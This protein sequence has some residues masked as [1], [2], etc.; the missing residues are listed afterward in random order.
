MHVARTSSPEFSRTSP[1]RTLADAE[2]AG[3][4][5]KRPAAVDPT[6]VID[7]STP[8][9]CAAA[10]VPASRRAEV[11]HRRC[12]SHA[13]RSRRPSWSTP[14][15]ASRVVQGPGDP[16]RRPVPRARG[17]ADR[18]PRRRVPTRSSSPSRPRSPREIERLRA[19][20]AEI[21]A[22]GWTDGV[23]VDVV[24]GPEEYLFGEETAL[25]EVIDGRPRSP[26]RAAVP[27]RRR[28]GRR[29][30]RRS[31]PAPPTWR[32]PARRAS[33]APPTLAGNVETFANVP[34]IVRQR[35]RLVPRARHRRIAGHRRLHGERRHRARGVAEVELG[36]PLRD[37]I[38][39]I[40]GGPRPGVARC[41][42]VLS[43]VANPVHPRRRVRHAPQ[44]RGDAGRRHAAR[45]RRVH[46][47]RRLHRPRGRRRGRRPVPRRRVVRPV[48]PRA[49][50]TASRS[51]RSL[52]QLARVAATG[53]DLANSPIR[54]DLVA[55]RRALLP[56]DPATGGRGQHPGAIP[57]AGRT[58]TSPETTPRSSRAHR[59]AAGSRR[60]SR[61]ARRRAT[62]PSNPTGPTTRSTPAS[63]RPTVSTTT[64]A[65]EHTMP[66]PDPAKPEDVG[67]AEEIPELMQIE[68]ARTL[69]NDAR[70]G[71][72][73]TVSTTP[74][75]TPGPRPSS[76]RSA[77]AR[78]TSSSPGSPSRSAG[79]SPAPGPDPTVALG[80]AGSGPG[81]SGAAHPGIAPEGGGPPMTE[82]IVG[83]AGRDSGCSS[84]S[85][86]CILLLR[87]E[88]N[89][90]A[91][92]QEAAGTTLPSALRG[93][94]STYLHAAGPLVRGEVLGRER[95]QRVG[96]VPVGRGHDDRDHQLAPLVGRLPHHR[97]ARPTAG[98]SSSTSSTSRGYTLY[99]PE[100]ISS[101]ARPTMRR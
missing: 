83:R 17:R 35:R 29:R 54:L 81:G 72:T 52:E 39:Q 61:H 101:L 95:E 23:A 89:M 62:A 28:R 21:A 19:A 44:L 11:A 74:R 4:G 16:A 65:E 80:T 63:G 97:D 73:P 76:P 33:D 6:A 99:P 68:G 91:G 82:G 22:A 37:V 88:R 48:P 26:Y 75:S 34:G 12:Q 79:P 8:P 93:S 53:D 15:R 38:D 43:G 96:V 27:P 13:R 92:L 66:E 30:R 25:L 3:E 78:S 50:R 1:V 40:G 47:V 2:H 70:D 57:R 51:P 14:P 55:D 36:T 69:G 100:M 64:A 45:R 67:V 41:V 56:R 7:R 46:R 94:S 49:S 60:R 24:T 18:G 85:I 20:I 31:A 59:R 77:R 86:A 42:A 71:C 90:R 84:A 9:A 58:R 10:A 87:P 32:W 5:C 98:C